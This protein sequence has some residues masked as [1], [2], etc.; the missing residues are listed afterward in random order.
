MITISHLREQHDAALSMASRLLDLVDRYR[1]GEDIHPVL[2]Q[3]NRL[4]G[5]LR[6]HLAQEDVGLYP[7]L[8]SS[9]DP[10]VART[11]T[12]FNEEMGGLADQLE[13]FSRHWSCSAS[14]VG[15]FAEFREG[16]HELA[17]DLAVRIE[18]ENLYLYPLAEEELDAGLRRD[19]A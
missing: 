13:M 11:A 7:G 5:L 8:M 17:L 10:H 12:C 6:V 16:M 3:F 2:M 4:F 9:D 14:L 19:A 15:N 1:P 18:R